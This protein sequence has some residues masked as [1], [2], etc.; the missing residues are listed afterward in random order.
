MQY[1]AYPMPDDAAG[2]PEPLAD[3]G[4]LRRLR[5]P[6]RAARPDHLPH[7]GGQGGSHGRA[8]GGAREVRVTTTRPVTARSRRPAT[9]TT[10]WS[11]TATTG[12]RAGRSR[13]SPGS[14]TFPGD[15][16]AR[17]LLPDPGRARRQAGGGA[18][19]RQLRHRHRRGVLPGGRGRPSWRCAA[20]R[21]SCRSSC[22]ACR[23]TTSPARRWPAGPFPVQKLGM[24]AMLRLARGKVTDYGLP[25]PDH[26]VLE[27]H[28]T[29]SDDLL[30][31]LGHGD[32][33]VKPNIDAVRRPGRRVH[34]RHAGGGR[35]GRLL[36]RLPG[37]LP[38]PGRDAGRPPRTTTSTSTAGWSPP[39]IP[40]STSSA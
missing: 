29:I 11:P 14:D 7:R 16:A 25:Q 22:S 35:R 27:A 30:T 1:A 36:H 5:R 6:L 17:A 8:T 20:A 33:A 31:R 28:P 34:R 12:T 21:T 23:P 15:A 24:R 39:T 2:L 4:V 9:T 10:C 13:R 3:R 26:D 37:Q 40:A 32:I 38:V 19:D 18:R